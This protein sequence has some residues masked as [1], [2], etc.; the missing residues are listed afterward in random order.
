MGHDSFKPVDE[1]SRSARYVGVY[2]A[3]QSEA[4]RLK[5]DQE[6]VKPADWPDTLEAIY[7]AYASGVYG[8]MLSYLGSPEETQDAVH[9]VFLRI[10]KHEKRCRRMKNPVGYLFKT[11]RNE[12]LSRLRK[13]AVRERARKALEQGRPIVEPVGN[14]A[15]REEAQRVNAA[16][17]ALPENQREVVMLKA[18]QGMTFQ[19]IGR[20]VRVSPNTAA[21]RYRYALAKLRKLLGD[22][23]SERHGSH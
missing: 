10:L 12:A 17:G 14:S 1:F 16:L 19:E 2:S 5:D 15:S 20:I 18:Y 9:D 4:F 8:F 23:G 6:K 3:K 22:G 11:A 21:S 13:R 7:D